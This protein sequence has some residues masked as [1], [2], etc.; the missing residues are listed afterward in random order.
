MSV[1]LNQI[2]LQA[3][4]HDGLYNARG[5]K[6][7]YVADFIN[8]LYRI[9]RVY[10]DFDTALTYAG[11][12]EPATMTDSDGLLKWNAHNTESR[13]LPS[14]FT[15]D[16]ATSSGATVTCTASTGIHALRLNGFYFDGVR[17]ARGVK[18]TPGTHNFMFITMRG[19]F[20][21]Y[22]T[23][24][25]DLSTGVVSE[26]ND[27]GG[28]TLNSSTIV[29][30]GDGSFYCAIEA[31]NPAVGAKQMYYG[32]AEAAT[33]NTFDTSTGAVTWTT[34][35][36]ETMDFENFVSNRADLGGMVT[37]PDTEKSYVDNVGAAVYLPRRNAHTFAADAPTAKWNAHNLVKDS[38]GI[39]ATYVGAN[40]TITDSGVG[41]PTGTNWVDINITADT[42][43]RAGFQ[44]EN[45]PL[46]EGRTG[47][48]L[49]SKAGS[50][51][52]P[53]DLYLGQQGATR[54]RL[55]QFDPAAGSFV[56]TPDGGAF[57][58]VSGAVVDNGTYWTLTLTGTSTVDIS[59]SGIVLGFWGT[60]GLAATLRVAAPSVYRSDLNG[61]VA[62]SGDAVSGL[63]VPTTGTAALPTLNAASGAVKTGLRFESTAATNLEVESIPGA[64][65]TYVA[66]NTTIT[67]NN[68]TSPTGET[69]ASLIT[70]TGAGGYFYN[71]ILSTAT[72][73]TFS[74]YLKQGTGAL[75][76]L[77][78]G[79]NG[80]ANSVASVIN[81]SAGTAG[82]YSTNGAGYT[83]V[84][85][86]TIE[87]V[88]NGWYRCSVSATT[89]VTPHTFYVINFSGTTETY[90]AWGMQVEDASVP[91]SHIPTSGATVARAAETLSVAGAL[92]PANTT[93]QS[94]SMSGLITYADTGAYEATFFRHYI[95]N[96]NRVFSDLNATAAKTGSYEPGQSGGGATDTVTVT[97]T[98]LTPG[99][100]VSFSIAQRHGA[101]FINGGLNGNI[102]TAN[103]TP[104]VLAD[105]SATQIDVGYD[106]N[107]FISEFV[108]WGVDI[109]DTGIAE[110]SS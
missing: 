71:T 52:G 65:G 1:R 26:T 108:M 11:L 107:G 41:S 32:F 30:N 40:A 94:Y 56:D 22:A 82:A 79:D 7:E 49:V 84:G 73:K 46:L 9:N 97:G 104:T 3:A 61:V 69:T 83:A 91:S 27:T 59:A 100:N 90:Y 81:L 33:G 47:Q 68:A 28:A 70:N 37:D 63:Y 106:F 34:V 72:T 55:R 36:T 21:K 66:P 88:G 24:V 35:G 89:T 12:T 16:R 54:L 15:L 102:A 80:A 18:V 10:T 23:A 75:V 93:A 31:T 2:G 96:A 78:I 38:Q 62:N 14:A 6:P 67:Q 76:Y 86:P 13:T 39:S 5:F 98:Q 51:G 17:E 77:A 42:S 105:L 74:C 103:T 8:D 50:S 85:I 29:D 101:A 58:D 92:T 43:S 48:I 19:E 45:W 99:V 57:S 60:G 53:L 95:T 109:D 87:D 20:N 64:G 44:V 25:F 110:A 4:A